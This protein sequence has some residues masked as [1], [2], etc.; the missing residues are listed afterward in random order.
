MMVHDLHPKNLH[1]SS[2]FLFFF[3]AKSKFGGVFGH[4]PQEKTRLPTAILTYWH[5]DRDEIIGP[6]S[7]QRLGSNNDVT[8][9]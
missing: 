8:I 7:T 1:I 3:L 5:T 9:G 6:L 2:L 4:Y